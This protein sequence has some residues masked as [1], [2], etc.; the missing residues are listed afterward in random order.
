MQSG[1]NKADLHMHT[2]YS[3]GHCT[4]AEVVHHVLAHTDVR[5]IAIT[6]HDEIAG[7]YEVQRYAE[8]TPLQVVI[9]EEVS[10]REG[11]IL[12]YFIHERIR[13]G[14]TATDT[15]AAIHEQ[16]GLAVAAHPYDWMVRSLGR[17]GL[18]RRAAG[19]TREWAFDAIETM[20]ASLRP[21][22]ANRQ[23]ANVATIL[24]LPGI[25]GSDSHVL[26]TIGYGVTLFEGQNEVALRRAIVT[27]ASQVA[28]VHWSMADMAHAGRKLVQRTLSTVV[29]QRMASFSHLVQR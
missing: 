24:G 21:R 13:A 5:M 3:D 23:A 19:D 22:R 11:H 25:G 1:W 7:A 14:M 28:G 26:D 10:S 16:G 27:G 20:N 6:D 8:G 18:Q 29:M 9:G 15:I 4:P 12:A 17:Y 2:V